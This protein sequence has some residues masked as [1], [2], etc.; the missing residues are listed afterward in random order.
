MR[1][2]GALLPPRF[3]PGSPFFPTESHVQRGRCLKLV[4]RLSIHP[5]IHSSKILGQLT[6]SLSNHSKSRVSHSSRLAVSYR[7]PPLLPARYSSPLE[8]HKADWPVGS[9]ISPVSRLCTASGWSRLFWTQ[10]PWALIEKSEKQAACS[11][12]VL[13]VFGVQYPA[14]TIS[15]HQEALL[16][17]CRGPK[18][19]T[20]VL[21]ARSP[22]LLK[23]C[24][25]NL[26]ALP[27]PWTHYWLLS[28]I[29]IL[30]EPDTLGSQ[31][32]TVQ[33]PSLHRAASLT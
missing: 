32:R 14:S 22:F 26:A 9:S 13:I 23:F 15:R 21:K 2:Y 33:L 18:I 10:E 7:W 20:S 6:G 4:S 12:L 1:I 3:P 5:S 24:E 11:P 25:S 31:S 17:L 19:G 16:T 29:V 8:T 28:L 30:P 27:T